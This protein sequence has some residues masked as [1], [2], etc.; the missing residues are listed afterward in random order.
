ML[1]VPVQVIS[2]VTGNQECVNDIAASEVLA[3]LLMTLQTLP[4]GHELVIATLYPLSSNTRI[5]KEALVKG[6]LVDV[7]CEF[8][9]KVLET[10]ESI[11]RSVA[12]ALIYLLDLYC[13]SSNPNIRTRTAEL[14]A[15]VTADKLVGPRVHIILNKFLPA[16]FMDAMRDSAEASVNMFEGE[17]HC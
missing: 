13:N 12:G 14:F 1:V 2:S 16:I 9:V 11:W 6:R 10:S 5:L 3:Y 15:K 7:Y 4:Q 8:Q 17:G